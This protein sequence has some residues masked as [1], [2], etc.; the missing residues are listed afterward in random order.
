M[1]WTV[2]ILVILA[3][4][5]ELSPIRMIRPV[6]AQD[7]SKFTFAVTADIRRYSGEG[8]YDNL[9]YFKGVMEAIQA[10]GDSAFMLSPGDIDPVRNV[11]WTIENVMGKAFL[12]YP[13]VGNHELPG[14]GHESYS[15]ENMALLR[16]Y[17]YDKNGIGVP[18]DIVNTGPSGCPE[19]T[20]SFDYENTHFVVL[21]EYCNTTG[22]TATDGNVS[23]HL[24][25]WL[26]NDLH[27]TTQ[28]LIFVFGH[29]PAFPQPDADNGRMRH[30]GDSLN[31][32]ATSRDR[33]WS[34]LKDKGVI[35]YICGHTHNYSV[36]NYDGVWQI[37]VGHARGAGD[38]GAPSTFLLI[39]V[40]GKV[41][42]FDA[43]RDAHDGDYD[44]NDIIHSGTIYENYRQLP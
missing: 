1:K 28:E 39:H 21:N 2:R 20:Y 8:T 19:T 10:Q 32:Y 31:A 18:P 37:D 4:A 42:T 24:Y 25:N 43:Y 44:Y 35:A 16:A 7:T 26:V 15:G 29:E 14:D 34:L 41:V 9:D 22:D 6:Y 36:S 30:E 27:D 40:N 38:I 11:M 17:D 23:E 12:W 13:V 3:L 33:F 5:T